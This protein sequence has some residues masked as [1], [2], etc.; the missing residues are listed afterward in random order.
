[1]AWTGTATGT[2]WTL[3][4]AASVATTNGE[5]IQFRWRLGGDSANAGSG[6]GGFGVDD[7][8]VTGLR[9]FVCEPTRNTALAP[10]TFCSVNA[11]GTP[12]DDA[13]GCTVSDVC[14]AGACVGTP[15]PVPDEA[16]NLRVAPDKAT[17]SYDALPRLIRSDWVRGDLSSLPVGPS[18]ETCFDNQLG[19]TF[20]D[21]TQPSPGTGW[22]Y[23]VRG[24]N[25]CGNGTYGNQG[26]NG[27][28][29]AAR[30]TS[31]CP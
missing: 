4:N 15:N 5:T 13:S 31:T 21:G 24:E 29:G 26:V 7:V 12:C 28:P 3:T 20:V 19:L 23:L 25:A 17:Y 14:S 1:L 30:V 10:C 8:T 9:N 22:W 6:Y 16:Q 11:N 2:A 18:G 27:S